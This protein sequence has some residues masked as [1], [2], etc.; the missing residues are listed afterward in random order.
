MFSAEAV[1]KGFH[2]IHLRRRGQIAGIEC[3]EG[4]AELLPVRTDGREEIGQVA[5]HETVKRGVRG[6][7][8]RR[9]H[10]ALYPH[11]GKHGKRNAQ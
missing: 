11:G 9:H 4:Q 5:T 10:A 1:E 3:V 8:G 6:Q 7:D 2:K